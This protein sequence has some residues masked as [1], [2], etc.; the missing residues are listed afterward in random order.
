MI[1]VAF[2]N[3]ERTVSK[4]APTSSFDEGGPVLSA[5]MKLA[6]AVAPEG[7]VGKRGRRLY[8]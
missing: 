6:S 3:N 5:A 1:V 8:S 4:I 2:G 7:L